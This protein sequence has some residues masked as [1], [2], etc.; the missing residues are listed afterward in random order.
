M[1]FTLLSCFCYRETGTVIVKLMTCD[2]QVSVVAGNLVM[3]NTCFE[4][5]LLPHMQSYNF[6]RYLMDFVRYSFF[7]L[8]EIS[9][10]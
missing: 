10:V 3:L 4:Y 6:I 8:I 1:R 5:V 2:K 7:F 9:A